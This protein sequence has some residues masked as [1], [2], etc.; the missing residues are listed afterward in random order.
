MFLITT[1]SPPL[2]PE[3][4]APCAGPQGKRRHHQ[5]HRSCRPP[6]GVRQRHRRR[7]SP[8]GL[9][10]FFLLFGRIGR[11]GSVAGTPHGGPAHHKAHGRQEV[12]RRQ[13]RTG[14]KFLRS[15]VLRANML[16]KENPSNP[17]APNTAAGFSRNCGQELLRRK[18]A[19]DIKT[20]PVFNLKNSCPVRRLQGQSKAAK[21]MGRHR[22]ILRQRGPD[23]A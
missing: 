22:R 7:R 14:F 21:W 10:M 13:P 23:H 20:H 18:Y 5:E 8:V 2:H 3:P 11:A 16:Q 1:M 15:R 4:L 12:L 6:C 17:L 9:H 19:L